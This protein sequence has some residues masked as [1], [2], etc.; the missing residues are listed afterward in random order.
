MPLRGFQEFVAERTTGQASNLYWPYLVASATVPEIRDSGMR[1]DEI[2]VGV[3]AELI[4]RMLDLIEEFEGPSWANLV[5]SGLGLDRFE[6][7]V[8]VVG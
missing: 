8:D 4:D 5:R 3:A 2:P 6:D 7:L 1:L